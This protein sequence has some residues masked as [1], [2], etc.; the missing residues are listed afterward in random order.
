MS[1][2]AI[3]RQLGLPLDYFPI[4]DHLPAMRNS[5]H[6][7]SMSD[8]DWYHQPK[9]MRGRSMDTSPLRGSIYRTLPRLGRI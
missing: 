1:P 6:H 9:T 3:W 2:L 5:P 7:G 8:S 4:A